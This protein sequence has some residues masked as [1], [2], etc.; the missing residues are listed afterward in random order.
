MNIAIIPKIQE[1]TNMQE[2]IEQEFDKMIAEMQALEKR[3]KELNVDG[4]RVS[5]EL[6]ATVQILKN[7]IDAVTPK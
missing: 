7:Q 5:E 4:N 6:S 1:C 3:I 2:K